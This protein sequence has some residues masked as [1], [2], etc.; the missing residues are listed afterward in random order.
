MN[1]KIKDIHELISKKNSNIILA[2]DNTDFPELCHL[3]SKIHPYII[4]LKIHNEILNLNSQEN[5]ALYNICVCYSI[6]LWED[7]KFNDISNTVI[8]QLKKYEDVRDFVSICPTSGPDILKI[9]SKLGFFVLIEMSS[10]N[11]LFNNLTNKL[12]DWVIQEKNN[13]KN[14]IC[15]IICQSEKYFNNHSNNNGLIT[16]K[17]GIHLTNT[18]DDVGQRYTS[19]ENIKN[20]PTLFVIGRGITQ[21]EKPIEELKK[22]LSVTYTAN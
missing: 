21:A 16:I 2:Y 20:K 17:P 9:K 3:L 8:K 5:V 6:F 13:D 4:G 18:K 10:D 12:Y 14:S 15:G 7:R 19:P 11:N 22:Y 1:N